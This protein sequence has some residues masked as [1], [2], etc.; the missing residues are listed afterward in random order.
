MSEREL[1]AG[2]QLAVAMLDA[3]QE[4]GVGAA[5]HEVM[6]NAIGNITVGAFCT[7]PLPRDQQLAI[8]DD[9]FVYTR[10]QIEIAPE[11]GETGGAA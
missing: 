6:F 9:W 8:F 7:L 3:A 10:Q 5:D 4:R 11:I 1:D 2:Q